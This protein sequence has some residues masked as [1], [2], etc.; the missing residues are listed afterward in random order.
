MDSKHD[1]ALASFKG[2]MHDAELL[3]NLDKTLA[4]DMR[5]VMPPKGAKPR[6]ETLEYI[7]RQR[8]AILTSPE[9]GDAIAY[10]SE[11]EGLS[12]IERRMLA[13]ASNERRG[14]LLIPAKEYTDY[15]AF[16]IASEMVWQEARRLSDY[17]M[18]KEYLKRQFAYKKMVGT[19]WGNGKDPMSALMN[20]YEE[21]LNTTIMDSIFDEIKAFAVPFVERYRERGPLVRQGLSGA[22]PKDQQRAFCLEMIKTIGYDLDAGRLDESAHPYNS[23]CN[24]CDVRITTRYFESD[25]T[26]AALSTLHEMGHAIYW[27]NMSPNLAGTHLALAAS[28]GFDESQS[29]LMENFIGRSAAFWRYFYP[30]AK[31]YFPAL[32]A[33]PET[34]CRHLNTIRIT[35]LRLDTDELTYNLHIILRYELEKKLF[36]GDLSFDDLP[37][38]WNEMSERLLGVRPKNDAEGVLQDM[39]WAFGHIGYFQTYVVANCYDGML[40]QKINR[41]IPGLNEQLALG[42]FRPLVSWLNQNVHQYGMLYPPKELIR[43]ITGESLNATDYINYLKNKFSMA[44]CP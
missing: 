1:K 37:A 2:M 26:L 9:M 13:F 3:N 29:R 20:P 17:G 18:L 31:A 8:Y 42:D 39:H 32:D 11:Q 38:A 41:D 6:G 30:R 14:L 33:D 44:F 24:R 22:Y 4:W 16:N 12:Q 7:A 10:L 27:Q 35:P 19:L 15:A 5:V 25:F 28:F 21:G 40:Y 43:N 36:S 23:S 34:L